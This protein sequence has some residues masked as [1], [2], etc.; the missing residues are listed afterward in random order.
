M[1]SPVPFWQTGE[2]RPGQT[3]EMFA[4]QEEEAVHAGF[5]S[6]NEPLLC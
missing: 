6:Q 4:D 1:K 2:K 3:A 5:F